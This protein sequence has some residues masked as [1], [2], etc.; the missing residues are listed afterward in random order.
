VSLRDLIFR[1]PARACP[2]AALR[3]RKP[4]R[5]RRRPR[6]GRILRPQGRHR[7]QHPIPWGFNRCRSWPETASWNFTL[8][9]NM[10]WGGEKAAPHML[11]YVGRALENPTA[12]PPSSISFGAGGVINDGVSPAPAGPEGPRPVE[13][14]S[15][16]RELR[17]G[18][19]LGLRGGRCDAR[20][21]KP[22][23]E[24]KTWRFAGWV[25]TA[26]RRPELGLGLVSRRLAPCL[27][28]PQQK[29][30]RTAAATGGWMIAVAKEIPDGRGSRCAGLEK[31]ILH[32]A[33]PELPGAS[34]SDLCSRLTIDEARGNIQPRKPNR[35]RPASPAGRLH[36]S[37]RV[38]DRR[39]VRGG[40]ARYP[41]CVV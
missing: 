22:E 13:G 31:R 38:M 25:L 24:N 7:G 18:T 15:E 8:P 27:R 33:A 23:G 40:P 9:C 35:R 30:Q 20:S 34:G 39:P 3:T 19:A 41:V 17:G 5:T 26:H 37:P 6:P 16:G 32:C 4:A 21:E 28:G 1:R 14:R 11:H 29:N 2:P 10:G 12:R 36:A